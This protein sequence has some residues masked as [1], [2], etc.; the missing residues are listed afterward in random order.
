[1]KSNLDSG[2]PQAIQEMG[3][4]ALELP[5]SWVT[6]NNQI[7]RRRRD[8]VV[9]SLKSIGLDPISPKAGLYVW[10][11]VPQGFSSAQFAQLLLDDR[12]IVVTPG[13]GYGLQGEGYI[14]LSLTTPDD[15]IEEG[16]GRLEGWKIPPIAHTG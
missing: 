4:A 7:Y 9:D 15:R 5:E 8:M 2:A 10:T 6:S 1:M 3:V 11:N 12:D 16:L 14:R 13:T